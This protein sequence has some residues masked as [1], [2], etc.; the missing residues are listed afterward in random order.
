MMT[1]SPP[2]GDFV[3]TGQGFGQG[4]DTPPQGFDTLRK[5]LTLGKVLTHP[6]FTQD[7]KLYNLFVIAYTVGKLRDSLSSYAARCQFAEMI[8]FYT[9]EK[10]PASLGGLGAGERAHA[11]EVWE[12]EEQGLLLDQGVW[13]DRMDPVR[14]QEGNLWDTLGHLAQGLTRKLCLSNFDT[15]HASRWRMRKL[16]KKSRFMMRHH[17]SRFCGIMNRDFFEFYL[18][19]VYAKITKKDSREI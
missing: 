18:I 8:T 6:Q 12:E 11:G 5:V 19:F 13:P 16:K 10:Q 14:P 7:D 4:F 3:I 15:R 1:K 17:E 9:A 2:G